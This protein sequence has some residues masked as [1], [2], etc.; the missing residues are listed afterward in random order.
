MK[1]LNPPS[2]YHSFAKKKLKEYKREK[3]EE[4]LPQQRVTQ[5]HHVLPEVTHTHKYSD[6]RS[7]STQQLSSI[8]RSL[9]HMSVEPNR[10]ISP[11]TTDFTRNMTHAQYS[12]VLPVSSSPPLRPSPTSTNSQAQQN[13][14][15]VLAEDKMELQTLLRSEQTKT[16][17]LERELLQ[18]KIN[19]QLSDSQLREALEKKA[20]SDVD[21]NRLINS[22]RE[23][24][25]TKN[26]QEQDII[27]LRTQ[28]EL[29]QQEKLEF[30]ARLESANHNLTSS[31]AECLTL[32]RQLEDA[33][34]VDRSYPVEGKNEKARKAAED[35]VLAVNEENNMLRSQLDKMTVNLEKSIQEKD[36]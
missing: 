30:Q 29:S 25:D 26:K 31:Q 11:T 14:L 15:T 2:N 32:S 1:S 6:I 4:G 5:S 33:I 9:Q 23:L 3:K 18:L 28:F 19:K 21:T 20:S 13:A 35:K 17:Q 36:R 24:F 12:T 8:S 34:L 27:Q 7:K 16:N 10:N 22:E